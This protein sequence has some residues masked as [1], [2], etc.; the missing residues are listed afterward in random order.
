MAVNLALDNKDLAKTYDEV[1]NT[2]FNSGLIL[3]E[4]LGVKPGDSVLDIGS[5]TGRLGRHVIGIIGPAGR[6]VGIDPLAERVKLANEQN[7]HSNAVFRIGNAE[8][9]SSLADN[10][11]DAVYLNAVFHWVLD[12]ETALKEIFKVLKPGGKLGITTGAKELN[13]VSGLS[14]LTESVLTR[15]PYDKFV[16]LEDSVQKQH[17][18]TTTALI[19]LLTK[20]GFKVKDIQIKEIKRTHQTAKDVIIHSEASSFGN[21]LNHVPDSLREQA[22]ADVAAEIEKHRTKD[23]IKLKGYTIFAIA[24]K[25]QQGF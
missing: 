13:L 9:L 24:K 17:G 15:E 5:G 4:K 21:Y 8:D 25:G 11:F 20:T 1:S 23:G 12:K 22:K 3:I 19:E 18:L 2:Q 14:L 16:R 10:N 7:E 6:Y